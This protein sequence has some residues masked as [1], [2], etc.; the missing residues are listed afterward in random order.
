VGTITVRGIS[1]L[2]SAGLCGTIDYIVLN[3]FEIAKSGE[4][5]SG[6]YYEYLKKTNN[7]IERAIRSLERRISEHQSWIQNPE[8]HL[9]NFRSPDLDNKRH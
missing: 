8:Q 7:E 6:L 4:K 5:H 9:P 3:A 1:G 2:L